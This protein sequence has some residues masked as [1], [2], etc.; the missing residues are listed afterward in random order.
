MSLPPLRVLG[1]R[2]LIAPDIEDRAPEVTASGVVLAHSLAAAVTGSDPVVAWSRGTVVALGTPRHPLREEALDLRT[3]L[4][5]LVIQ[6]YPGSSTNHELVRDA[7]EMLGGL[8]CR[9]PSVAIGDDVLFPHDAGQD[10]VIG[11][12]TYILMKEHEL[13]AVVT[14]P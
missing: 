3:R 12:Q 14:A 1:D 5:K 10:V 9:E 6:A 7:A 4:E 8:V 2:V 13:L 11:D